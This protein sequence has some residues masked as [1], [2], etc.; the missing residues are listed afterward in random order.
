MSNFKKFFKTFVV[1]ASIALFMGCSADEPTKVPALLTIDNADE[2]G[3]V[4]IDYTNKHSSQNISFK[5]DGDWHVTSCPDWVTISPSSGTGDAT[6]TITVAANPVEKS[7]STQIG[8]VCNGI[9]QKVLL[10]ISQEQLYIRKL[11]FDGAKGYI[12]RAG[13]EFTVEVNPVF[14][15]DWKVESSASWLKVEKTD[16]KHVKVT[17]DAVD[18][19]RK[20]NVTLTAIGTEE[21]V[22]STTEFIQWLKADV[23]DVEFTADG[24]RDLAQNRTISYEPGT[25]CTIAMNSDFGLYVPS[26]KH[27]QAGSCKDGIFR[28][29]IDAS[30]QEC[31]ND[32]FSMEA[33]VMIAEE[34]N[35]KETKPFAST[36]SGGFGILVN[37]SARGSDL[38][39]LVNNG[40]WNFIKTGVTPQVGVYY[41]ILGTWDQATGV[42]KVYL[43]GE[44]MGTFD[45]AGELKYGSLNPNFLTIGANENGQKASYNGGWNGDVVAAKIFDAPLTDKEA[46][47]R[48]H[49]YAPYGLEIIFTD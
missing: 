40:G 7:R 10:Q 13:G 8:F 15:D 14:V 9:E 45:V 3:V 35:G 27:T 46:L 5:A 38:S 18:A 34:P 47:A 48:Y 23:L 49:D 42:G 2:L 20:A 1:S 36:K 28:T 43:D 4:K 22:T 31:L 21:E 19:Q 39:F 32:G 25:N 33:V 17:C 30:M 12:P 37:T 11:V 44:L 41:H 26:F 16:A 29:D 24:A 6:V